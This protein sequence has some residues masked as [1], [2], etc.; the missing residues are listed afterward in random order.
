MTP[1]PRQAPLSS[2]VRQNDDAFSFV[3]WRPV[4]IHRSKGHV[5]Y[6][7][8]FNPALLFPQALAPRF[9]DGCTVPEVCVA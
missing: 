1:L 3:P 2:R 5:L 9:V 4:M 6:Y 7:Y 8:R